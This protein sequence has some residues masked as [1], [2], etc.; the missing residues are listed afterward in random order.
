MTLLEI[1]KK[2]EVEIG[3]VASRAWKNGLWH[4]ESN[5]ISDMKSFVKVHTIKLIEGEIERLKVND[6]DMNDPQNFSAAIYNGD[7]SQFFVDGFNTAIADQISYYE[8]QLKE[9]RK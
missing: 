5:F 3:Q 6:I 1:Q 2:S 7:D 4:S 9:L 8:S